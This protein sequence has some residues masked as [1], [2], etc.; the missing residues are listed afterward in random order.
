MAID[1]TGVAKGVFGDPEWTFGK[2]SAWGKLWGSEDKAR[3]AKEQQKASTTA[4]QQQQSSADQLAQF[5]Q[6]QKAAEDAAALASQRSA[7]FDPQAF[8]RQQVDLARQTQTQAMRG[9]GA[10]AARASRLGGANLQGA[11]ANAAGQ[12]YNIQ[13]GLQGQALAG[14]QGVAAGRA[15]MQNQTG[16]LGLGYQNIAAGGA[17]NQQQQSQKGQSDFL[18]TA[19]SIAGGIAAMMSDKRAKEDV[20]E[21]PCGIA[22]RLRGYVYKY[23]NRAN[24]DGDQVGVMAQDLEKTPLR[25]TVIDTPQGKVIHGAKLAGANTA[26]IADLQKQIDSVMDYVR[27]AAKGK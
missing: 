21:A 4:T 16:N 2:N 11:V 20:S 18:N 14:T 24:G 23:K 15:G 6:Q 13:Q 8:Q 26:M 7:Q 9:M 1:W 22:R 17:Q 12:G 27:T 10:N 5:N 19:G 3:V 25:S